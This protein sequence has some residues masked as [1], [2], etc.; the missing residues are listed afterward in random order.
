MSRLLAV[1]LALALP[2]GASAAGEE[3]AAAEAPRGALTS[4]PKDDYVPATMSLSLDLGG[5]AVM[6]GGLAYPKINLR[7]YG[8]DADNAWR[9]HGLGAGFRLT[10]EFQAADLDW[11][12]AADGALPGYLGLRGTAGITKNMGPWS[13]PRLM[14]RFAGGIEV[15][16]AGNSPFPQPVFVIPLFL[17]EG[18]VALELELIRNMLFFGPVMTAAARYGIPLGGGFDAGA[19]LR[20]KLVF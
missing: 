19:W 10:W 2:A 1:A 14:A 18:E 12:V 8:S 9:F 16:L 11:R 4:L 6:L 20:G 3:S 7:K 5:T 17:V 13:N 15:M